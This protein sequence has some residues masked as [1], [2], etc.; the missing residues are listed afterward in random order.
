[1]DVVFKAPT[2]KIKKILRDFSSPAYQDKLNKNL[3]ILE[4]AM[5]NYAK[6][7]IPHTVPMNLR[8]KRSFI[9]EN[10]ISTRVIKGG[11][12]SNIR[13]QSRKPEHGDIIKMLSEGRAGGWLIA[14]LPGTPISF[15]DKR[16]GQRV[17]TR[18]QVTHPGYGPYNIYG[19]IENYARGYGLYLIDKALKDF[20]KQASK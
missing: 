5:L 12:I 9:K 15:I 3:D 2:A 4:K 8:T 17:T 13:V 20:K 18:K 10:L 1:M 7:T 11:V 6:A 14:K 16:D 19:T